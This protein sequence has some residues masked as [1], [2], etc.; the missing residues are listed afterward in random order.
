MELMLIIGLIA[1]III[2]A[3][4]MTILRSLI[5]VIGIMIILFVV[6]IIVAGLMVYFDYSSL[7]SNLMSSKKLF[8]FQDEK[9][10]YAGMEVTSLDEKGITLITDARFLQLQQIYA[11]NDLAQISEGYHNVFIFDKSFFDPDKKVIIEKV[12]FTNSELAT[13]IKSNAPFVEASTMISAKKAIPYANASRI[14]YDKFKSDQELKGYLFGAMIDAEP[15]FS[16]VSGI[17]D[18]KV[19]IYPETAVFK[20]AR[21]LPFNFLKENLVAE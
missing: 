6:F 12:A 21:L 16:F 18:K 14:F 9:S 17:K 20:A 3:I 7:S 13:I 8:L 11:K 10:I 1:F 5:R 4:L 19:R 2:G 15:Q